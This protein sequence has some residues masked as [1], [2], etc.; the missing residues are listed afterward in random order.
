MT[1]RGKKWALLSLEETSKGKNKVEDDR[2]KHLENKE[3]SA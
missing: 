2:G 1:S 3:G